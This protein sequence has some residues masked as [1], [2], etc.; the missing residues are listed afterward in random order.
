MVF[1]KGPTPR[2][3]A[4]PLP[5]RRPLVRLALGA[6]LAAAPLAAQQPLTLGE[7]LARAD[8]AGYANRIAAGATRER[9]GQAL[10]P[11]RGILPSVRLEAAYLRTTD[12]L[13]SFGFLLR[14]RAVTPAAFN[15]TTLNDPAAIGN[16][17]TGVVV[18]QPLFNADAWLGRSAARAARDATAAA[19]TW[20]RGGTAVQ[21]VQA[22]FGAVLAAEQVTTLRAASAAGA[23]HV[24]QAEAMV[25]QGMA[26]R[27]DALLASVKAGEVDAQLLEAES[28]AR[29]ARRGLATLL[30]APADSGWTLPESLPPLDAVRAVAGLA[31]T[32]SGGTAARADVQAAE[33]GRAAAEADARRAAAL[34]LP[35]LNGFGRLDW[36]SADAPFSGKR[37]WTLGVM[38]SWS[39][40]AGAQ[41]LAE[42]RSAAGRRDGARAMAQAAGAQ[43]ALEIA[44]A[45][46]RQAV[47]LARL[48]IADRS[49]AQ[50]AEAHRIVG[51]KYDGGLATVSE[52][53]D[54][55]TV[56]TATR[57]GLS[58]AR[59]EVIV[60]A[61][62]ARQ[63]QGLEL[64]ALR[65]LDR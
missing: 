28:A 21:V 44:A 59:Y 62:E 18:E 39:P 40:F 65:A 50:A 27:S 29:Q 52:L 31:G 19:E 61:A 49:V 22:Y 41:E 6:A 45:R 64:G 30:G 23:A 16:L 33:L 15:P 10:A 36:N 20:T 8:T 42:R 13:N 46:D 43:A 2:V 55:A 26:T 24:R 54:A 4:M 7:A 57:L 47:A 35:R 11:Y 17:M 25:R 34:Y 12:P 51:R 53:L 60:A 9:A 32:D 56:E 1:R 48:A 58:A 14:Q 38:L 5:F 63:A 37:A 3:T